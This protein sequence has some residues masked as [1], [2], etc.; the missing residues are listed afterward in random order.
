ML[1]NN[2]F[3][4]KLNE[5]HLLILKQ[6][7]FAARVYLMR[8]VMEDIFTRLGIDQTEENA[9]VVQRFLNGLAHMQYAP[10]NYDVVGLGSAAKKVALLPVA[11]F[12]THDSFSFKP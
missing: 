8:Q 3:G 6:T 11:Q 5:L 7:H 10:G 9:K 2:L 12:S 1:L 4:T